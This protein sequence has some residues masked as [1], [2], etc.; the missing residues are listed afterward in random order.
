M[1]IH[2]S[3]GKKVFATIIE[4]TFRS[5]DAMASSR[6]S[7]LPTSMLLKYRFQ[8]DKKIGNI[9]SPVLIIHSKNDEM[10]DISHGK[11]LFEQ[12]NTPK[13]FLE[14]QGSHNGGF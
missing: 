14:I 3:Q 10:I 6:Y 13:T 12:A 2:I 4:S 5:M 1:A 7:F 9:V 8:S 11:Y